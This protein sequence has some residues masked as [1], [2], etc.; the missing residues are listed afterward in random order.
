MT[1]PASLFPNDDNLAACTDLYQLTMAAGYFVQGMKQT[2]T[3]ELFVRDLPEHRAYLVA[4]GLEQALHYLSRLR[5]RD[6]FIKYLRSQPVFGN[7]PREFFEYLGE[8]RFLGDVHAA[9]EGTVMFAGEPILRVTAPLLH[10]QIVETYLLTTINFQTLVASKASRVVGAAKGRNV[11]DFGTRRAHGPQAGALAARA[12]YIAGCT[13]TSNVMA[14]LELGIP[15]VGT[16]AHSWTMAFPT[17]E[18]AFEKYHEVFPDHTVLLID[19]YDTVQGAKRAIQIGRKLRGVRLDSGNLAALAK[20]V[21]KMLDDAGLTQAKIVASGDLNEYKIADLLA[22]GAPIDIFGVGTEMVTSRDDPAIGGVY[23]IVEVEE[24]G[25]PVPKAKWSEDKATYPH[26]KQV[27]RESDSAG[28]WERDMIGLADE[29]LPGEP[30]LQPA[31]RG[32]EIIMDMP[33]AAAIRERAL[34]QVSRLPVEARDVNPSSEYPVARSAALEK[35]RDAL[36]PTHS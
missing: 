34:E 19:T 35:A 33:T 2:A 31:M 12:A 28:K 32:G 15:I 10:A 27:F 20:Q 3:F 23:K 29:D 7:V 25:R 18:E 30:V 14:G 11:V 13:A 21:R 9:P 22:H 17:E 1:E 5:F 26:R 6:R 24:G 8:F 16:A 36:R 4:A